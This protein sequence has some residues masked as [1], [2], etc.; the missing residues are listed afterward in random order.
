MTTAQLEIYRRRAIE[1]V[2]ELQLAAM[3]GQWPTVNDKA[4][5]LQVMALR[6][7]ILTEDPEDW[8]PESPTATAEVMPVGEDRESESV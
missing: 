6:A 2:G 3:T 5:D 7:L 8:T 1:L 4:V